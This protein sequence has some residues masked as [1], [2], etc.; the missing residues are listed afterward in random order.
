MGVDARADLL[1]R[2]GLADALETTCSSKLTASTLLGGNACASVQAV[3]RF[4]YQ[5]FARAHTTACA[6]AQ[7]WCIAKAFAP[8]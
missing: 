6:A 8:R 1:P 5:A 2:R 3:R 4:V 7:A